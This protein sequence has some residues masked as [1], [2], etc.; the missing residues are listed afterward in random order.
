VARI[1]RYGEGVAV[2]SLPHPSSLSLL[3]LLLTVTQI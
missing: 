3:T 2:V 1:D